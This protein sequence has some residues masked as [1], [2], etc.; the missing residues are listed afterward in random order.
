[1][2]WEQQYW[3][4]WLYW[5]ESSS[6]GGRG[7]TGMRAAVLVEP[8]GLVGMCSWWGHA[9][10]TQ[11]VSTH[12]PQSSQLSTTSEPRGTSSQPPCCR[13][14][15]P[16]SKA[17]TNN[18]TC[19][20]CITHCIHHPVSSRTRPACAPAAARRC[21]PGCLPG[22][23]PAPEA[24]WPRCCPPLPTTPLGPAP[25][26]RPQGPEPHRCGRAH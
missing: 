20:P 7:C 3:W 14:P 21:P 16:P 23:L 24:R 10:A 1:M 22:C 25:P 4:L 6:I 18:S 9:K 8:G 15:L 17:Y 11:H 2:V 19:L 13:L 26:A 5:D 12:A